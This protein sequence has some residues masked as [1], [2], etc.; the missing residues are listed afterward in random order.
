MALCV[1]T[2][3]AGALGSDVARALVAR[4]DDVALVDTPHGQA[5]AEALAKELGPRATAHTDLASALA[6]GPVE[7]AALIAGG[8]SGGTPLAEAKDDAAFVAMM[9]ANAATVHAALRALLPGMVARKSGA[10]V[11]VGS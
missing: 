7:F 3:G 1:V 11:V 4:G 5:R 9:A 6:R 8:W 2:G 10:I